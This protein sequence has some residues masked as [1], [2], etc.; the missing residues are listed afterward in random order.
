[1]QLINALFWDTKPDTI[2]YDQD[3]AYVIERVLERGNMAEWTAIKAYYGLD[4][5]KHISLNIRYL[6]KKLYIFAVFFLTSQSKILDVGNRKCNYPN[7]YAGFIE[8]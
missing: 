8:I 1:M 5:I 4:K 3:A 6:T 7:T 2:D